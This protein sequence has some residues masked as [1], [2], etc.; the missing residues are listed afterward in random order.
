M[1][2]KTF[3]LFL[4]III[5]ESQVGTTSANFLGIGLGARSIGMGGAYTSIDNDPG[6]IY[7]NPGAVSRF[8]NDKFLM[9]NV[10][11]LVDT[12]L[13][14]STYIKKI[15]EDRSLG[16][17]WTYLDYGQ[18]EITDLNNQ[19]GTE[20][21]WDASDLA[22]GLMYSMNLT[23]RFS[24]GGGIKYINQN[25]YNESSS[26]FAIDA[27]LLYTSKN[28]DFNIGMSISNVGLDMILSGKDLYYS[29][30]LD[31]DNSGNN[32]TIIASLKT[33]HFPLPIFYRMGFSMNK[34]ISDNLKLL[35][36][37][38]AVI[39][40]DDVEHLNIGFELSY[41]DRAF[42]RSGYREI[43]NN[44]SEQGLTFGIGS[45][46]YLFG[47]DFSIDYAY[48]DFGIWGYIPHIDFLINF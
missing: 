28:D 38:D 5:S 48:Q 13:F 20:L 4:S 43:G 45:R 11:W 10:S 17:Y 35:S 8:D 19:G 2:K 14:F 34:E 3:I 36:S 25:I 37:F 44:S 24:F 15:S 33:D 30:D 22:V 21:Y 9:S 7:W 6:I 40:S 47:L 12:Q 39:P 1:I 29:I 23:D 32:E 46:V 16:V 26:S 41:M 42:L 31:P 18:E 27:G